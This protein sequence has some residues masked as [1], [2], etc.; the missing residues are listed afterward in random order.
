MKL[1]VLHDKPREEM[2]GM[3]RFIAAQ[4]AL[5]REAGWKVT[6]VICT[7]SPQPDA[8]HIPPSGRRIGLRALRQ[9]RQLVAQEQPDALIAHSV[10]FALSPLVLK[11]LQAHAPLVYVLHDVTP[12]CPR[13]T[14]LS[15]DGG[16]C[17]RPQGVTC[18]SSGCYR[19]GQYNGFVSDTYGLAIRAWHMRV[20]RSVQQWVVPSH[21]LGDLLQTQGIEARRI[22]VIPHFASERTGEVTEP[23]PCIAGRILFAGRLVAEKGIHC[24]LDALVHLHDI[25]WCLHI[26][27]EGPELPKVQETIRQRGWTQ[28]VYCLG[29]LDSH[30]LKLQY[31]AAAIVAMPS[32]IPESFGMVGLEAMRQRRPVVGFASGGMTEWLRHGTSGLVASWGDPHSLA[33]GLR[34]LL[35][36]P[37]RATQLGNQGYAL[38]MDEYHPE[39]HFRRM[40]ALLQ[41][42]APT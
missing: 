29:P 13:M 5:F 37:H 39:R 38:A 36:N 30:G 42:M 17:Q 15:R 32:L 14:R 35:A 9:L 16:I 18:L 40:Q 21:Y 3:T 24:L 22:A 31:Q 28:R 6:E 23:R 27:G 1:L 10:Y 8:I 34:Q 2:G 41:N 20:A 26:A 25:P 12:L 33:D 11:G 19:P 7:P 4:N